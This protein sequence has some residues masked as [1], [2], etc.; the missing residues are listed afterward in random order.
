MSNFLVQICLLGCVLAVSAQTVN[1]PLVEVMP[2]IKETNG[3]PEMTNPE[4][5]PDARQFGYGYRR[6]YY[7]Q[8]N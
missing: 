3:P 4:N 7:G 8:G 6:P 1:E 2:V 5:D